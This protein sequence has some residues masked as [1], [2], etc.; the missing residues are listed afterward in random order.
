MM[1]WKQV[2]SSDEVMRGLP[3]LWDIRFGP[4]LWERVEPYL[5]KDPRKKMR[6]YERLVQLDPEDFHEAIKNLLD[7]TPYQISSL[8]FTEGNYDRTEY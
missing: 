5:P 6:E 1:N 3:E 8:K 2:S 7:E 4:G